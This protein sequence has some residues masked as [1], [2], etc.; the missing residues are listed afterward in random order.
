M[1]EAI[2]THDAETFPAVLERLRRCDGVN[3]DCVILP[4]EQC[5]LLV[6]AVDAL[7]VAAPQEEKD[8]ASL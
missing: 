4:W 8:H 3:Y 1:Q 6:A 7:R 5:Q 2:Y